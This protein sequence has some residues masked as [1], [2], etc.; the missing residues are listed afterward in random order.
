[1]IYAGGPVSGGHFNPAITVGTALAGKTTL[2]SMMPDSDHD[3][4]PS[5]SERLKS[6]CSVTGKTPVVKALLYMA[7]QVAGAMAATAISNGLRHPFAAA[8]APPSPASDV[9]P[10]MVDSLH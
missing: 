6:L 3:P 7:S 1:M 10:W 4:S 9:R 8:P 5:E 2:T